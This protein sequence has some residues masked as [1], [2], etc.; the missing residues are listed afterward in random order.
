MMTR[1]LRIA[2][3]LVFVSSLLFT[4]P[5]LAEDSPGVV[6]V[7]TASLEE[8]MLLPR[9]GPAVGSRIVEFREANGRFKSTEDLMLVR[10]IGERTYELLEAYVAV[11]GKTT[12]TEKI[13]PSRAQAALA[14]A[15]DTDGDGGEPSS[16]SNQ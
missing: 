9:V 1:S 8:L 16:E 11:D 7:N 14:P 5:L 15:A 10:G 13:T 3:T 4:L 2:T 6:N 12:L